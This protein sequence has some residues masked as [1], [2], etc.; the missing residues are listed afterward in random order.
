MSFARR[1]PIAVLLDIA[2]RSGIKKGATDEDFIP[3]EP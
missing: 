2:I 3:I 1:A